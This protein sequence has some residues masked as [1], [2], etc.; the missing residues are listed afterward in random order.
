MKVVIGIVQRLQFRFASVAGTC[1]Y[2]TNMQAAPE[3]F[4]NCLR[5]FVGRF[6]GQRFCPNQVFAVAHAKGPIFGLHQRIIRTG[7]CAEL[8]AD[9]FP[10]IEGKALTISSGFNPNRS[11]KTHLCTGAAIL[12]ATIRLETWQ[13]QHPWLDFR[14]FLSRPRSCGDSSV[15]PIQSPDRHI[16]SP[17]L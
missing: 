13:T 6:R 9:T 17:I 16:F 8:A 2:M 7:L 14:I 4:L 12:L 1:V 5:Q 15:Q 10:I 11:G 3:T